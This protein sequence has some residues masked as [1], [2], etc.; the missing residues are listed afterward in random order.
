MADH[1]RNFEWLMY[2][3]LALGIVGGVIAG[4]FK[5]GDIVLLLV[6]V[7]IIASLV[8]LAAHKAQGWAAWVL[9]AFVA[10]SILVLIADLSGGSVKWLADNFASDP[11]PSTLSK[12]LDAVAAAMSVLAL[13]F[14]FSRRG[15]TA[16]S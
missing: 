5:G 11:P 6:L 7:A 16:Q 4:E 9:V 1:L 12:I 10:L 14:Y 2:G 15:A 13:W 8:W 3:S